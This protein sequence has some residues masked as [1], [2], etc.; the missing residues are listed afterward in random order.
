MQIVSKFLFIV[1]MLIFLF[2]SYVNIHGF[3]FVERCYSLIY[4]KFSIFVYLQRTYQHNALAWI[5]SHASVI[6]RVP[7][8]VG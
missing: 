3:M 5:L 2:V 6:D 1:F 4:C 8:I 7:V